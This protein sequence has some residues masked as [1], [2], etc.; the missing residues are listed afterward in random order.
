MYQDILRAKFVLEVKCIGCDES[1]QEPL[2]TFK[3]VEL[4]RRY[5]DA[6]RVVCY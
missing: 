5:T 6:L 4:P 1:E 3:A 2:K